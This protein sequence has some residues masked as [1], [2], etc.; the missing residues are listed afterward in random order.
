MGLHYNRIFQFGSAIAGTV[1]VAC[2]GVTQKNFDIRDSN[3]VLSFESVILAQVV[4]R[5]LTFGCKTY[6]LDQARADKVYNDIKIHAEDLM[7]DAQE[8]TRFL[9]RLIPEDKMP[10]FKP[11]G[12]VR[13]LVGYMAA[14]GYTPVSSRKRACAIAK[15]ERANGT[16]VGAYLRWKPEMVEP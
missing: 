4:A 14:R 1:L 15:R 6:V 7:P 13:K 2:S 10:V 12:V 3:S 11:E 8:R 16:L 9:K 5:E